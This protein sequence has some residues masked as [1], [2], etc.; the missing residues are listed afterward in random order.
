[1]I[2]FDLWL[3][4]RSNE[5]TRQ[6]SNCIIFP[7]R[8]Y[9]FQE[10]KQIYILLLHLKIDFIKEGE[11]TESQVGTKFTISIIR[12]PDPWDQS[13]DPSLISGVQNK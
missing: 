13:F 9:L 12:I 5:Q 1:M 10:N 3:S 11:V 2:C 7:E 4:Q 8:L 6:N